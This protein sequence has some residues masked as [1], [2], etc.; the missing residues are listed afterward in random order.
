MIEPDIEA[1]K[2]LVGSV[3]YGHASGIDVIGKI[4]G[5]E[6]VSKMRSPYARV[7]GI[8]LEMRDSGTIIHPET[9][10]HRMKEAGIVES[11]FHAVERIDSTWQPC[12]MAEHFAA[13]ITKNWI[14][15][16]AMTACNELLLKLKDDGC[17]A[18]RDIGD[19]VEEIVSISRGSAPDGSFVDG[20]RASVSALVSGTNYRVI[21][22]GIGAFDR[23]CYGLI[24]GNHIVIAARPGH[25]K[26]ALAV[27]MMLS[28]AMSG[29]RSSMFS[30]E[31]SAYEIHRRILS[32]VSSVPLARLFPE[33]MTD[34][35]RDS[36][37]RAMSFI[38]SLP[39]NI[40][41]RNRDWDSIKARIREDVANGASV[42]FIDYVG[43][44]RLNRQR[45]TSYERVT[46]ISHEV[47]ELAEELE[48][49]IVVLVQLNREAA[50]EKDHEPHLHHLRDAGALEEDAD[51]VLMLHQEHKY[52][53]SCPDDSCRVFV[54]KFRNGPPTMFDL[55]W[56]GKLARMYDA[57]DGSGMALQH[58]ADLERLLFDEVDED[59]HTLDGVVDDGGEG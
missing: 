41:D 15:Y 27:S 56:N 24:R 29:V 53:P 4:R 21:R 46:T 8:L 16:R 50:K 43:L 7:L 34:D 38:E 49:P 23:C 52:D 3:I 9:L 33:Y 40:R 39:I 51:I 48:V 11:I 44:V 59:E 31:M 55:A 12:A 57:G 10:A 30:L 47:K 28:L 5:H 17:D 37:L 19:A 45:M 2:S 13:K 54:R 58:D 42:V 22:T 32:Q 20:I 14:R 26:T 6:I 25:G 36:V 1:E 35:D 18:A